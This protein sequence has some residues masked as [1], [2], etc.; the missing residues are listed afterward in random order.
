MYSFTFLIVDVRTAK[1]I[2]NKVNTTAEASVKII[3]SNEIESIK[4]TINATAS[5]EIVG[6]KTFID[7]SLEKCLGIPS[8]NNV[9]TFLSLLSAYWLS[10]SASSSFGIFLFL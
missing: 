4:R 8:F 10:Y 2:K 9:S 5:A 3:L 1:K 6:I 7:F